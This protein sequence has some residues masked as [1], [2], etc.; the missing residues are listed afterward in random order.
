MPAIYLAY[1][2]DPRKNSFHWGREESNQLHILKISVS[3]SPSGV[4]KLG[5]ARLSLPFWTALSAA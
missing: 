3:T 4:I 5:T 2:P 1:Y